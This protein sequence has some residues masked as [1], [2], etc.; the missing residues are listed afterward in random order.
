[1]KQ[2]AAWLVVFAVLLVAWRARSRLPAFLLGAAVP[3]AMTCGLL[4][5]LG[6]FDSFWFWAT[7]YPRQYAGM[8]PIWSTWPNF[9]ANLPLA[10]GWTLG[11]WLLAALGLLRRKLAGFTRLFLLGLC[12]FSFLA[13][14]S[15]FYFRPQHFQLMLPGVSL[16]AGVATSGLRDRVAARLSPLAGR[17]TAA[18]VV[19]LPLLVFL[20]AEREFLFRMDGHRA[21]RM[22]FGFNPF[23]ESLEIAR[24]IA[25]NSQPDDR[26][27]I[28][29]SE[30][31]ILF[32]ARRRSATPFILVY[33]A[34]RSHEHARMM[35]VAMIEAFERTRPRYVVVV[36]LPQ[37]WTGAPSETLLSTWWMEKRVRE[38]RRVGL[39]DILSETH[40]E[41]RWGEA[42]GDERPRSRFWLAVW[43]RREARPAR[44]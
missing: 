4:A 36:N 21:S 9:R 31:Q 16:L 8:Q 43:E 33:E 7:V 34:T 27:A 30:P 5:A 40:T 32:Y 3:F 17:A 1:M 42:L 22:V 38:F 6:S 44:S 28:L 14:A 19:L 2:N 24:F 23:P 29:G 25:E 11:F 41:Y 18:A 10:V 39:I 26:I 20:T 35:Q 12:V 37:S 13:V 15:G